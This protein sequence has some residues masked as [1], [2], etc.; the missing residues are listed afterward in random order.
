MNVILQ[1][2]QGGKR[3]LLFQAPKALPG[4][5]LVGIQT[6]ASPSAPSCPGMCVFQKDI[7]QLVVQA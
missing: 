6:L 4:S 1:L 5:A 3:V 2:A 7:S